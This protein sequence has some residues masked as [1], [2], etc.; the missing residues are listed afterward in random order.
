MNKISLPNLNVVKSYGVCNK[1][2]GLDGTNYLIACFL[3]TCLLH[4]THSTNYLIVSLVVKSY[5][6]CKGSEGVNVN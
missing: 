1:L 5:G 4:P 6:V 2:V 3:T